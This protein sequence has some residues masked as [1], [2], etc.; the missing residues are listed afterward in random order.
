MIGIPQCSQQN[1]PDDDQ[2]DFEMCERANAPPS[3]RLRVLD[4]IRVSLRELSKKKPCL[5]C[6]CHCDWRN[7]FFGVF[8]IAVM[9]PKI[10]C[11]I[12]NLKIPVLASMFFYQPRKVLWLAAW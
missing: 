1:R 12:I 11:V 7:D 2:E 3:E 6:D 10:R 8:P 5:I 9:I 4:S